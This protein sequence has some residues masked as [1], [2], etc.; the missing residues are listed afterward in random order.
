MTDFNEN[1][2]NGNKINFFFPP[3]IYLLET[4]RMCSAPDVWHGDIAVNK[5]DKSLPL[6]SLFFSEETTQIYIT[7]WVVLRIIEGKWSQEREIGARIRV[8]FISG[9]GNRKHKQKIVRNI[10]AM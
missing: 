6:Y 5:T 7:C 3:K 2:N 4:L 9:I 1:K 10:C 8:S